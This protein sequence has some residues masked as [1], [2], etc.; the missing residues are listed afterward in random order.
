MQQSKINLGKKQADGYIIPIGPI[1]LVFI[2]TDKGM[3]GCGAFDVAALNNFAYPAAKAKSKT[4]APIATI[5]DLM[6]GTVKE[7]NSEAGK[8]G[9]TTGMSCKAA[10]EL[11]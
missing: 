11:L 8:L 4:G 2:V 9:I 10:L 7:A 5:E 3:L 6:G 1:N